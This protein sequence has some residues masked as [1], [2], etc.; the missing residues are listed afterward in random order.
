MTTHM[1]TLWWW[2][3]R[4][5]GTNVV[6]VIENAK[7]REKN[8]FIHSGDTIIFKLIQNKA[9]TNEVDVR[10]LTIHRG[11]WLKWVTTMPTKNGFFFLLFTI[12][13]HD[14]E[15]GE[16]AERRNETQSSF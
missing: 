6:I 5:V 14:T 16:K 11:W 7:Y 4:C 9:G 15:L 2:F 12:L 13:A 10:Y 8:K 3:C 1:K